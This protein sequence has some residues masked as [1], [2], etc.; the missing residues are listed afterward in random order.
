MTIPV[1]NMESAFHMLYCNRH[2]RGHL[3]FHGRFRTRVGFW[4]S[5]ERESEGA[6]AILD[7]TYLT[8][9]STEYGGSFVFFFCLFSCYPAFY[10]LSV[11]SGLVQQWQQ[12]D[13]GSFVRG[14]LAVEVH[15]LATRWLAETDKIVRPDE[16]S[17]FI[18]ARMKFRGVT[19]S[20]ALSGRRWR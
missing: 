1:Q 17:K 11:L 18:P 3:R 5:A 20:V 7:H 4:L 8:I 15:N 9:R 16:R 12:Q 13:I 19:N 6:L 10:L 2:I 14:A